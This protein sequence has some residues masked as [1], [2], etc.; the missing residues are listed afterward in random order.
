MKITEIIFTSFM[1]KKICLLSSLNTSDLT[2]HINNVKNNFNFNWS[3]P[4]SITSPVLHT[5]HTL[6]ILTRT[7]KQNLETLQK[8]TLGSPRQN[9]LAIFKMSLILHSI[10]ISNL[11]WFQA[12]AAQQTRSVLVW[13]VT[14]GTGGN[15]LLT[16]E[17]NILVPSLTAARILQDGN[18]KLFQHT[19]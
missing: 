3:F 9:K 16:Y 7:N 6:A 2:N 1:I 17:D 5:Q 15:S 11:R 12:S 4:I 14:Q 13:Y 10:K 8:E 18:D 19:V